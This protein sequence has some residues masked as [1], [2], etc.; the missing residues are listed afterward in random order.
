MAKPD[1]IGVLVTLAEAEKRKP[2]SKEIKKSFQK[3][4]S[5]FFGKKTNTQ[6]VF[7]V[8]KKKNFK[9]LVVEKLDDFW[10][11]LGGAE[12]SGGG[13]WKADGLARLAKWFAKCFFF[14][15]VGGG[16]EDVGRVEEG[17][18]M[19]LN[20]SNLQVLVMF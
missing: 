20:I 9:K 5:V 11:W 15:F 10:A 6:I 17:S 1:R 13:V 3:K 2:R 4:N 16:F 19:Q 14:F 7:L 12:L 8:K 18:R